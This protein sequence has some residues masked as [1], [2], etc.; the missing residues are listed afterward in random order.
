MRSLAA[1]LLALAL[2]GCAPE[3]ERPIQEKPIGRCALGIVASLPEQSL[4]EAF[5]SQSSWG[6]SELYQAIADLIRAGYVLVTP[7][8]VRVNPDLVGPKGEVRGG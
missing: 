5:D 8:G 2:S 1:L 3:Q 4:V 6:D 7:K